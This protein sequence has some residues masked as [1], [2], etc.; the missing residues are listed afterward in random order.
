MLIRNRLLL[1]F[2]T[3]HCVG[4]CDSERREIFMQV[5]KEV[6][7]ASNGSLKVVGRAGVGVDNVDLNAAT[8]V[9]KSEIKLHTPHEPIQLLQHL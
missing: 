2:V 6:F 5:T 8:Q 4:E 7:E 1:G 9:N 3:S